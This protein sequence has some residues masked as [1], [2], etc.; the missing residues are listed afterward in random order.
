MMLKEIT[1]PK[2]VLVGSFIIALAILF[3]VDAASPII[4]EAR[5]EIAGMNYNDLRRDPDFNKAVKY[6]VGN[7]TV[8]GY[9][10]G[11]KLYNASIACN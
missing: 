9:I 11:E 8:R 4:E 2:A 7:C 6:I 1:L 10:K 5:A 3:R